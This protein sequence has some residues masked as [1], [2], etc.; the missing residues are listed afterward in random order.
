MLDLTT[1]Y[2]E[3]KSI[4]VRVGQI[5]PDSLG[6]LLGLQK[7]DVIITINTISTADNKS[8]FALYQKVTNLG[9]DD[10][11]TVELRRNN[12]EVTINYTLQDFKR[13]EGMTPETPPPTEPDAQPTPPMPKS[14]VL[15][16][17]K[18][19]RQ[20]VKALQEKYKFAP[21]VK[22]IRTRERQNMIQRGKLPRKEEKFKLTE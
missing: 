22:D 13:P 21:T 16:A 1:L 6:A 3:G 5:A 7:N 11:I 15:P 20:Q 18:V 9:E 10:I 8:R 17:E 12:Q 14:P 2:K 19:E 4:G